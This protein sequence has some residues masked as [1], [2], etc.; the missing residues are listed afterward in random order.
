MTRL[1]VLEKK[2]MVEARLAGLHIIADLACSKN[3]LGQFSEFKSFIDERID[4]I[5]LTKVGEAYHDFEGGG[6]TGVVC[7]AESHLSIHTWPSQGYATFDV[8]LSNFTQDNSPKA[9]YLYD[10]VVAF[11]EASVLSEHTLHR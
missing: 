1:P 5:E 6:F 3:H 9:K 11:F 7:L 8:F 10:E 2:P 4:R